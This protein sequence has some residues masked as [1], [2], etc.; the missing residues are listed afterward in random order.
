MKKKPKREVKDYNTRLDLEDAIKV[1]KKATK[2]EWTWSKVI[3]KCVKYIF[4]H[5]LDKEL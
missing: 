4:S 2:K 3:S 5:G 1:E